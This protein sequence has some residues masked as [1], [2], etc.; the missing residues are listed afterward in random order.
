MPNTQ[1][2]P[3]VRHF[4]TLFSPLETQEEPAWLQRAT[5]EQR[6]RLQ[7]HQKA[8]RQARAQAM[9]AFSTL[10]SLYDFARSSLSTAVRATFTPADFLN[11]NEDLQLSPGYQ[12]HTD[13]SYRH[14]LKPL[15][16]STALC[17]AKQQAYLATLR[18]EA[19]IATIK[20]DVGKE[21]RT[22]LKW[23]LEAFDSGSPEFDQKGPVV[24]A[25][26]TQVS[27]LRL[28]AAVDLDQIIVFGPDLDDAPCI[29]YVP[30]HPRHPLKQY[31]GRTAFFAS[32]RRDWQRPDFQAFMRRFIPLSQQQWVF[33]KWRDPD[34]LLALPMA[35]IPLAQGLRPYVSERMTK[36]LL[37]DASYLLPENDAQAQALNNLDASF[38][39]MIEEH[40]MV[41]AG[42]GIRSG[43]EE[44]GLPP[45]DWVT[46]L[47][48]VKLSNQVN[49]RWRADLSAYQWHLAGDAGEPDARGLHHV[50]SEKAIRINDAFYQVREDAQGRWRIHMPNDAQAFTPTLYHNGAG[51]WHHCL[52]QPE[53]WGRLALLR[54]L[55]PLTRDISDERLL[56]LA[57]VSGVTN[58]QLRR[59]YQLDQPAPALL[60]YALARERA[61]NEAALAVDLL[62]L[63]KPLPAGYETPV[64][65]S[66]REVVKA[67]RIRRAA[68]DPTPPP[69][70]QEQCDTS[71]NAPPADLFTRWF[72]RLSSSI[73]EHRFELA[74]IVPDVT[75]QELR[76]RF[77]DMPLLMA[78]Q[79]LDHNRHYIANELSMGAPLP[80][81]ALEQ[82]LEEA[83]RGRLAQA[84]DGLMQPYS[85]HQDTWILAVRLLEFLPGWPPGTSL[86]LRDGGRFGLPLASLGATDVDTTSIYLDEDEG[87]YTVGDQVLLAQDR[88]EY[89]FYRSLLYALSSHQLTLLGFGQ[90]EPERLHQRLRELATTRPMRAA[91]LLDLPVRRR[92]LVAPA[93]EAA[94]RAPNAL[95]SDRLLD[96]EPIQYRLRRLLSF[97]ES[98]YAF[99]P[100]TRIVDDFIAELIRRDVS[101]SE[102][103]RQLEDERVLLHETFDNWVAQATAEN[104]RHA[105]RRATRTLLA[106]WEARIALRQHSVRLDDE[107]LDELPPL[108]VQL[109]AVNQLIVRNLQITQVPEALLS[110]L[111][112]LQVLDLSNLPLQALPPNVGGLQRLHRLELSQTRLTPG[113]LTPLASLPR[114]EHLSLNDIETLNNWTADE[115]AYICAVQTLRSLEISG[116]STQFGPGVFARLASLPLLHTLELSS[117]HITLTPQDIQ[118]LAGLVSLRRLNLADNPLD[119]APD[120][121]RMLALEELD[122][123]GGLTALTQWPVGLERLPRI[124]CVNL[125]R[126]AIN[127][128]PVGAG[129]I[130]GLRMPWGLLPEPVRA[131]FLRE[132]QAAGVVIDELD[133]ESESDGHTSAEESEERPITPEPSWQTRM[134][135]LLVGMSTTERDQASQL[136]SGTQ[137]ARVEFFSLLLRIHRSRQARD[138]GA[139]MLQR[140]QAVIRG[141]LSI[142]L[143]DALYEAAGE[144][145]TC[146]DRDALVFSKLETLAEADRALQDHTDESATAALLALGTSHWRALR[147]AEHVASNV[148]AWQQRGHAIE[149]SEL[150]LYFRIALASRLGLRNQPVTQVYTSYTTWVTQAMLDAGEA[151]VLADQANLLPGYLLAQ[152]YWQRYLRYAHAPRL[153]A[154]HCWRE[155]IGE[156][157]D[158]ISSADELPPALNEGEQHYLHQV[159]VNSGRLRPLETVLPDLRLN[160][161]QVRAAYAALQRLVDQAELDLTRDILL[162]Q[163]NPANEPQPGPSRR[164]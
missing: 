39:S 76:R 99:T 28:G 91:L 104:A 15:V 143:R 77:P 1:P 115:M 58:A 80:E 118:D 146:A 19:T 148:T 111:P 36:R 100:R 56:L 50:G 2:D 31:K 142:Q 128:V 4:D 83:D 53:C 8:G 57:R 152:P 23:I 109:P 160:D 25:M 88:S 126:T 135:T 14:Y 60:Q 75:V 3:I 97:A 9:Q 86:L 123:S 17:T 65:M 61:R 138:I 144:A 35:C 163:A 32:L 84:L 34:G 105:R 116:S 119:L 140:L 147:L 93:T 70:P 120:V 89:G 136:I 74:Q 157:L 18:E 63:G 21:G 24:N 72:A 30:G 37:D 114:L 150:E 159:L 92:W 129:A 106:G 10:L 5:A 96:Q 121:S 98:T 112:N 33:A 20:G 131:R 95:A 51:A 52:E 145:V 102:L 85:D 16:E 22:I 130:H 134:E 13:R 42:V 46:P 66:F 155:R 73:I 81:P 62:K 64:V 122:L 27:A 87:W 7:E 158:A 141:A 137:P 59:V 29:A 45:S 132:R 153:A 133:S 151:A 113:A 164:T 139:V 101:I 38:A 6:R 41:G 110:N 127:D 26:L 68:D 125:R 154:I 117:N 55:G 43:E 124:H 44:E 107:L 94:Y 149:Y 90:N 54:R 162:S 49:I 156:F 82:A 79:F 11:I 67:R 40:L 161:E 103:T 69:V 12:E 47:H 71:C 108:P 78:Q 48:P